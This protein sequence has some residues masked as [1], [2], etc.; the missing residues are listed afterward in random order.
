[1]PQCGHAAPLISATPLVRRADCSLVAH[2]SSQGRLLLCGVLINSWNEA[3]RNPSLLIAVFNVARLRCLL[4]AHK[5]CK[6]SWERGAFRCLSLASA[7]RYIWPHMCGVAIAV[8]VAVRLQGDVCQTCASRELRSSEP[9]LYCLFVVVCANLIRP[10]AL[11]YCLYLSLQ[12]SPAQLEAREVTAMHVCFNS[13][14][15]WE[16]APC[17]RNI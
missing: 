2:A 14:R 13:T 11:F 5:S 1:M 10:R 15:P 6:A 16:H 12:W 7:K 8:A 4:S 17:L 9:D 3:S